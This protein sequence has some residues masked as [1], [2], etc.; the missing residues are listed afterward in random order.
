[1]CV[2]AFELTLSCGVH[3]GES[4]LVAFGVT[5][6]GLVGLRANRPTSQQ[7]SKIAPKIQLLQSG[8]QRHCARAKNPRRNILPT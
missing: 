8:Q 1:M 3:T 7:T 4:G 5:V 2:C 6:D